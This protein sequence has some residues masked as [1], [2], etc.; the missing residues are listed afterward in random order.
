MTFRMKIEDIFRIG[1]KTILTGA[2]ET[3]EKSISVASCTIAI[4][5]ATVGQ[6]QISGEIHTGKPHRDLWTSSPVDL[7]RETVKEHD[8]W[9]IFE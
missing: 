5:G 9:L 3:R 4:D 8:V 6:L 7:N 1:E 2:L